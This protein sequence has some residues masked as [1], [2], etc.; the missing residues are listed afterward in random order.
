[1]VWA[2]APDWVGLGRAMAVT[3]C[4]P[5]F[6]WGLKARV[7]GHGPGQAGIRVGGWGQRPRPEQS[8]VRA[9]SRDRLRAGV[10]K[11]PD[12]L[13]FSSKPDCPGRPIVS[14]CSCP[15]ELLSTYL[16][17]IFD[18]LFQELPTN[19]LDTTHALHLLQNFQFPGPQYLI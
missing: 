15:T 3:G 4:R 10:R 9:E 14:A 7:C 6:G 5:G 8:G 12:L 1:M 16:D 11:L 2:G 13:S 17:T 18:P 19:V